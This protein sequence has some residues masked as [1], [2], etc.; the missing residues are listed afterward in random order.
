[1]VQHTFST[2]VSI[3]GQF[4]ILYQVSILGQVRRHAGPRQSTSITYTPRLEKRK[5]N[6]KVVLAYEPQKKEEGRSSI[7]TTAAKKEQGGY[8]YTCTTLMGQSRLRAGCSPL[9]YCRRS[10]V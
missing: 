7:R 6:D 2:L 1:M 4:S 9:L 5:R 10:L 3:L 8:M